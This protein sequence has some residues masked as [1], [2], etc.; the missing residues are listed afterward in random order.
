MALD[1]CEGQLDRNRLN[2]ALNIDENVAFSG[3]G[4]TGRGEDAGTK[5]REAL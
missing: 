1:M 3:D 4:L 2:E 5:A